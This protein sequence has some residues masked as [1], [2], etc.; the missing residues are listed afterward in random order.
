MRGFYHSPLPCAAR[1]CALI[2]CAGGTLMNDLR[3]DLLRSAVCTAVFALVFGLIVSCSNLTT[4]PTNISGVIHLVSHTTHNMIGLPTNLNSNQPFMASLFQISPQSAQIQQSFQ[5]YCGDDTQGI[6]A[7]AVNYSGAATGFIPLLVPLD[8]IIN[9]P[10][11]GTQ[12]GTQMNVCG[13]L[14]L[15]IGGGVDT[16]SGGTLTNPGTPMYLD[17]ALTT[18]VVTGRTLSGAT[19]RCSD[20][21]TTVQVHDQDLVQPYFVIANNSVILA[22]G[23]NQL[24]FT[25]NL[26]VPGGDQASFMSVQWAKI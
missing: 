26:N 16:L 5:G 14:F 12:Q 4:T 15:Q 9:V 19:I 22:I 18:L 21:S 13:G 24:P 20:L 10:P 11:K 25:C 1:S 7:T 17:G 3:R 2:S 8:A 23:T 6:G